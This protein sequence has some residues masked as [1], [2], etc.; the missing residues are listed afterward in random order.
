MTRKEL[1]RFVMGTQVWTYTSAD[2]SELYNGETYTP[3][4]IGHSKIEAKNELSKASLDVMLDLFDPLAVLLL[5][6]TNEQILSF[7]L[8]VQEDGV[9]GTAWKGRL[10]SLK[11]STKEFKMVFESVFTSLRRPGLRARYQKPCR[12]AIYSSGCKVNPENFATLG[13]L[14]AEPTH[15]V[16]VPEAASLQAGWLIGGMLRAPDGTLRFI[17]GHAG[18][19]ITLQRAIPSLAVDYLAAGYGNNYGTAYGGIAVK[20]YPGCN[21]LKSTCNDKFNNLPNYGG[22][23]WIPSKNP[24]GGSSIV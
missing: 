19:I 17:I 6:S 2:A 21:R 18:D 9:Y 10:A 14:I 11:P 8:F 1:F 24:M 15:V 5:R 4:P 13:H 20:L 7:T 3:V 23:S 12:H 22:F 16:N